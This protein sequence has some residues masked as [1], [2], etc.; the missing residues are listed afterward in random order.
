MQSADVPAPPWGPAFLRLNSW[1]YR[2]EYAAATVAVLLFVVGWYVLHALPVTW[3]GLAFFWFVWPDL[4]AFVPIGIAQ[5]GS[6]G[7]PSWGPT[8]YN[9]VHNFFVWIPVFL[10][11]SYFTGEIAWPL[12]MWAGHITID[13]AAGF[14]LRAPTGAKAA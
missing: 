8:L 11:W 3:L 5:R 4:A 14:Y 2:A 7:W 6:R 1:W 10:L 12:L 13:R 9:A